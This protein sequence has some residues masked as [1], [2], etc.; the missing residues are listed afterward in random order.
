[1]TEGMNRT[2]ID[3]AECLRFEARLMAYLERELSDADH[4]WMEQHRAS[5]GRCEALVRD[6]D[7]LVREASALPAFSPSRDLWSGI[8]ERLDAPVVPLYAKTLADLNAPTVARSSSNAQST[9]RSANVRWL[10]IAATILVTVT[11]AVTWRIARGPV[12]ATPVVASGALAIDSAND[13]VAFV[14]VVNASDVYEQEIAALRTIVNERFAELD[15]STVT[16]LKRNLSIIDRAIDDSRQALAKDPN[17]RV[18]S[19][20]LDRALETKLSLMRR[21]ALL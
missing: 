16:Q 19:T 3:D 9:R 10:A 12:D 6:I 7:V 14:P 5:C 4:Q 18:L 17:S 21:L 15:S 20:T 2:P 1:M 13:A 8:A 11:S